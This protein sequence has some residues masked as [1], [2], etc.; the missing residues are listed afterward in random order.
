MERAR[1]SLKMML[2]VVIDLHISKLCP[3]QMQH[4]RLWDFLSAG[5]ASTWNKE[6][7]PHTPTVSTFFPLPPKHFFFFKLRRINWHAR[8]QFWCF[9]LWK[10]YVPCRWFLRH[11]QGKTEDNRN[12]QTNKQVNQKTFSFSIHWDMIFLIKEW[13]LAFGAGFASNDEWI[14]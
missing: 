2:S 9:C 14:C 3:I 4:Q 10:N 6:C 13:A 5:E 12:K 1:M 8:S 11:A 7:V